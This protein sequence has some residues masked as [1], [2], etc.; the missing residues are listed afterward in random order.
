MLRILTILVALCAV[1]SIAA[2]SAP[3]GW[4][5]GDC[6]YP[7]FEPGVSHEDA[8]VV[9]DFSRIEANPDIGSP[10]ITYF[11]SY[12]PDPFGIQW[13]LDTL[14]VL[15]HV[16]GVAVSYYAIAWDGS[17]GTVD[18]TATEM[19]VEDNLKALGIP[20]DPKAKCFF[21]PSMDF[22]VQGKV[23]TVRRGIT[24]PNPRYVQTIHSMATLKYGDLAPLERHWRPAE[25]CSEWHTQ[26][27][28]QLNGMPQ[29]W[30]FWG[31]VEVAPGFSIE[32]ISVPFY[33]ERKN[34]TIDDIKADLADGR[35]PGEAKQEH[36]LFNPAFVASQASGSSKR[37]VRSDASTS[38][39]ELR[40]PAGMP[41]YHQHY[42]RSVGEA[43]LLPRDLCL[44]LK[45]NHG[46][47]P[48][49][50]LNDADVVSGEQ[51]LLARCVAYHGL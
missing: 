5:A 35:W 7:P 6:Q 49:W 8:W 9:S 25:N 24:C 14:D 16:F 23:D 29:L 32:I 4:P 12:T 46:N 28:A 38:T 45:S 17:L 37:A 43:F 31:T 42:Q 50:A 47:M 40:S 2:A 51:N 20:A 27:Y 22:N 1:A 41:H 19:F 11:R 30:R 34:T 33:L 21:N 26:L 36:L 13:H 18:I 15:D 39:Y 44:A 3:A 48:P 10:I